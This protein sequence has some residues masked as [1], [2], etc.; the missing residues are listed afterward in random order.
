MAVDGAEGKFNVI[1][2]KDMKTILL[3]NENNLKFEKP[4]K[5]KYDWNKIP[6]EEFKII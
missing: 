3:Y 5:L 4:Y 1:H 2:P 6:T